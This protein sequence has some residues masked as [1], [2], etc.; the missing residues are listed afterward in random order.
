VFCYRSLCSFNNNSFE[1][2][3]LIK[4]FYLYRYSP[5]SPADF[6]AATYLPAAAAAAASAATLTP[7]TGESIL[8]IF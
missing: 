1:K 4:Y 5:L 7:S 3:L 2:F 6:F 8:I